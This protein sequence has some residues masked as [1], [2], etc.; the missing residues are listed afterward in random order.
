M[1]FWPVASEYRTSKILP[2]V[3]QHS[4]SKRHGSVFSVLLGGR[5]VIVVSSPVAIFSIY[6]SE[7]AVPS[8]THNQVFRAV[9]GREQKRTKFNLERDIFP[10][11]D[12]ALSRRALGDLTRS[13]AQTMFARIEHLTRVQEAQIPIMPLLTK[14]LYDALN[15]ILLGERFA[16]GTYED[17]NILDATMPKRLTGEPF[18]FFPSMQARK[19]ISSHLLDYVAGS[20][21]ENEGLIGGKFI[22]ALQ[23][24]DVP[25]NEGTCHLLVFIWGTHANMQGVLVWLFLFLLMDPVALNALREEVDGA[26]KDIFGDLHGFLADANPDNLDGPHFALLTS[27]I[28]ET[29]RLT[30]KIMGLRVATRDFDLKDG[31]REI[32]VRKG[33]LLMGNVDAA[34]SDERSYPD[35]QKFVYDRFAHCDQ[36][37]GKWPTEGKPW[38][39][40]GSGRHV[41]SFLFLRLHI[42][43]DVFRWHEQCKGKYMAMYELKVSAILYLHLFHITPVGGVP[44]PWWPLPPQRRIIGIPHAEEVI[45]QVRPR[46]STK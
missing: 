45:V 17:F 27:A 22:K 39:S 5:N 6:A 13:L 4:N 18:W 9:I 43:I 26:I 8:F 7:I 19:R 36:R 20:Q 14:P 44:A 30:V 29:M 46:H 24:S 2:C 23:E 11:L 33:E 16:S 1:G 37:E 15:V 31:D 41:V 40:M 42:C 21:G 10:V 38:F 3:E 35:S 34:H 25:Q 28:V 32:P 12:Q